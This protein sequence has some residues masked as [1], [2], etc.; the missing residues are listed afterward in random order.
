MSDRLREKDYTLALLSYEEKRIFSP[1]VS[2]FGGNAV[3]ERMEAIMKTNK[4]SVIGVA[5]AV[6]LVAGTTT[7]FAGA[8]EQKTTMSGDGQQALSGTQA[9]AGQD[10][11]IQNPDSQNLDGKD[12]KNQ[13]PDA[14]GGNGQK[15]GHPEQNEKDGQ[16]NVSQDIPSTVKQYICEPAYYTPEEFEEAMK[17]ERAAIENE[18]AEG[19]ITQDGAEELLAD[20]EKSYGEVKNGRQIEKPS[21]V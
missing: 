20:F 12:Q 19:S 13:N 11:K 9:A 18:L 16:G 4:K 3:R 14:Q 21:P 15:P 8:K 5:M 6:V 10:E 17:D 7:V 1:T 2:G